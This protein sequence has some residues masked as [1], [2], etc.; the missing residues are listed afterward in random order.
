[1]GPFVRFLIYLCIAMLVGNAVFFVGNLFVSDWG[2]AFVTFFLANIGIAVLTSI[3]L[4][5]SKTLNKDK[6]E[7]V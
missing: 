7:V 6:D 5:L 4:K 3:T 1:M 2:D